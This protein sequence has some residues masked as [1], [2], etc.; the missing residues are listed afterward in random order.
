[1]SN[2]MK[3]IK[4]LTLL[5]FFLVHLSYAQVPCVELALKNAFVTTKNDE[6]IISTG[7]VTGR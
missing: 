7:K 6:I 5:I 2:T 4:L 1:M 3:H